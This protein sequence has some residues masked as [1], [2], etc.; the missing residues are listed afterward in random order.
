MCLGGAD[1]FGPDGGLARSSGGAE[2]QSEGAER[3][4]RGPR[5]E[6]LAADEILTVKM[7]KA[8]GVVRIARGVRRN[9]DA[10]AARRGKAGWEEG[11]DYA[12]AW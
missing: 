7:T 9:G 8:G 4:L 10:H 3:E 12:E 1:D 5:H 11:R 6:E 2:T